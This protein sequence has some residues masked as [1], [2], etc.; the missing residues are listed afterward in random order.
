MLRISMITMHKCCH[1]NRIFLFRLF[2][3]IT[4][5]PSE[6]RPQKTVSV[7]GDCARIQDETTESSAWFLN[8]LGVYHRHMG[9]RFKVSSKK[10]L[11]IVKLATHNHDFSSRVLQQLSCGGWLKYN[12]DNVRTKL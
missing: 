3:V 8:V 7:Y 9:P 12:L 4:F 6:Q 11:V 5:F 1:A 10:Q 2:L